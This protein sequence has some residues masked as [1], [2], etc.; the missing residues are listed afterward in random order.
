[1]RPD[2]RNRSSGFA[3]RAPFFGILFALYRWLSGKGRE[4]PYGPY[5]SMASGLVML[6]YCPIYEYL[7]PGL[8]GLMIILSGL[9]G[10]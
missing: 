4:V 6:F 10:R 2:G 9:I 8:E 1:M 3:H 5:L 7:Y